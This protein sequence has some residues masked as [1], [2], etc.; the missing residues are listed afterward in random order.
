[1]R[2]NDSSRIDFA[3]PCQRRLT[4][5]VGR[6]IVGVHFAP[7]GI[8]SSILPESALTARARSPETSARCRRITIPDKEDAVARV[9]QHPE[10]DLIGRRILDHH[11]RGQD[12][13]PPV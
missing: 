3:N 2:Q 9:L 8:N 12:K 4:L 1:M 5:G 7:N 13:Q 10:R 6:E 11:S